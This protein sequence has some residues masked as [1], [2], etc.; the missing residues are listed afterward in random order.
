MA[1]FVRVRENAESIAFYN[2]ETYEHDS[3]ITMFGAVVTNLKDYARWSSYLSL[4]N[5]CFTWA[6]LA[7]PY[8]LLAPMFFSGD[9][10][11]GVITQSVMA[12]RCVPCFLFALCSQ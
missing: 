2:G 12:F 1:H 9:I 10:E 8:I 5:K 3:A 6:T 4:F 11:F 7:I